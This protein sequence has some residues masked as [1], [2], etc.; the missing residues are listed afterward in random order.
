MSDFSF[1][2]DGDPVP[3]GSMRVVPRGKGRFNVVAQNYKELQIWRDRVRSAAEDAMGSRVAYDGPVVLELEFKLPRAKRTHVNAVH[4]KKPDVDKLARGV[5]DALSGTV[6]V[7]DRQVAKL[8]A[9]KD[10]AGED[11][12]VGVTID[13]W[14]L[15]EGLVVVE[16]ANG[17][18]VRSPSGQ[19]ADSASPSDEDPPLLGGARGDV[20]GRSIFSGRDV[21]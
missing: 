8:T 7:D 14:F 17:S 21:Q 16:G 13:G 1:R 9:E 15:L 12:W 20:R 3:Q 10:Y 5:L 4:V 11:G 2:V 19:P 6:Y 18:A